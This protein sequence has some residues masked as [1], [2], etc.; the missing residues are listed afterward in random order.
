MLIYLGYA[1]SKRD[2]AKKLKFDGRLCFLCGFSYGNT[3]KHN[4]FHYFRQRLGVDTFHDIVM[5]L[6]AQSL[7]NIKSNKLK[8]S[9]DSTHIEAFPS[10]KDAKLGYK[11]KDFSFFGYKVH[12][13]VTTTE[14]PVIVSATVTEGNKWDGH[15]LAPLTEF[16]QKIAKK[17]NKTIQAVIADAGYDSVENGKFLL[18]RDIIPYIAENPRGRKNPLQ[19]GFITVTS[20]GKLV[21]PVGIELCYW[22]RESKRGR[23]KFRCGLHKEKGKGCLFRNICYGKSDYGPCFYIKEDQD[24]QKTMRAIRSKKSFKAT[25]K[26][27]TVIERVNNVLKTAQRL[28]QLRVRGIKQVSIHVFMSIA[29]YLSRVIAGFKT[30]NKLVSV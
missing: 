17:N 15:F 7:V 5:N 22:G 13:T 29:A 19:T 23:I 25:Y 2:L 12:L 3:P 30:N 27:R 18:G 16:A 21:C 14:L 8:L 11:Q 1:N 9:I 4:T 20:K 24:T 26:Q 28:C 6:I 10:D